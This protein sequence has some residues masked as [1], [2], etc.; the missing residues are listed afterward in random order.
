MPRR[1]VWAIGIQHNDFYRIVLGGK[2][3]SIIQLI[4]HGFV[5]GISNVDAI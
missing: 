4:Q 3:K 1:K 2:V 5:L